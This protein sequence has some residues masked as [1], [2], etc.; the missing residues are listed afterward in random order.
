MSFR[1]YDDNV[2]IALEPIEQQ[3]ASG[4]TLIDSKQKHRTAIVK[5]V[6][7]GYINRGGFRVPMSV[8]VGDRVLVEPYAGQD[9]SADISIPRHNKDTRFQ[10][11]FGERGEFRIVREEEILGVLE[12]SACAGSHKDSEACPE[13]SKY[14]GVPVRAHQT[15]TLNLKK[16]QAAE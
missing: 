1:A 15:F 11:L 16:E 8:K 14:F 3:T 12:C 7:P 2:V 4:L 5:A 10:E 13:S 9:Y 6:G